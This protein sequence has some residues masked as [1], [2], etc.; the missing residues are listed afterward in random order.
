M[1]AN[2]NFREVEAERGVPLDLLPVIRK[3][4]VMTDRQFAELK[5]KVLSGEYPSE[6]VALADRLVKE[7][8]SPSIRPAGS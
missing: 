4:G 6:S 5:A 1:A 3:S 2:G 7:E 8:S